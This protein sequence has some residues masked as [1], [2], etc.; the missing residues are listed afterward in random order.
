MSTSISITSITSITSSFGRLAA[1]PGEGAVGDTSHLA[2]R[3]GKEF[4]FCIC[5]LSISTIRVK[6]AL[7]A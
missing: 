7:H 6:G 5:I 2:S 4:V 3:Q 1:A